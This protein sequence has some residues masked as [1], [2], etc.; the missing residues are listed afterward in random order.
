MRYAFVAAERTQYPVRMLCRVMEVSTSGF[1]DYTHRQPRP[2]PDAQIRI[3]LRSVY[4]ASRHTYGRPRLVA[5]L[6]QK[7]YA[8]GHKRVS[9]LMQEEGIHGKSKR[10]FRP[11]TTDSNHYL[12][13]ANN[14]VARQF[15][16]DNPTPTWVS[17]ITYLPTREGWLYLAVVL[18][19]QTR[20]ILG[21]S[22][23]DRMPDG[24]VESAFLNAW[25]ACS[26]TSGAVFHSDQGPSVRKQ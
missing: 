17:D 1:Y 9:R 24:L 19:I 23:S 14:V 18:S 7:S 26:G 6:R 21:Y 13:V 25:S 20:Q 22:L 11:C 10:G 16:I 12:P 2:D 3:E 5:A 4:A 8:V 15:A